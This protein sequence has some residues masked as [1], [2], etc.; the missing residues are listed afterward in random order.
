V[1]RITCSRGELHL[2]AH[3]VPGFYPTPGFP[4]VQDDCRSVDNLA[5]KAELENSLFGQ[6][7]DGGQIAEFLASAGELALKQPNAF[8]ARM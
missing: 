5:E 4:S 2:R 7:G 1:C 8:A 3:D 6:Q